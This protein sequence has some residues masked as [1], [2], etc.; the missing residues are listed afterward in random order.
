MEITDLRTFLEVASGKRITA[1]GRELNTVPSNVTTRIKKLEEEI[2]LPL[3]DRHSRGMILTE[4]GQRLLPYAENLVSLLRE[5][6]EA[7]QDDGV[8]R[9]ALRIG[10]METTAAVRL[11]PLLARFHRDCPQVKFTLVTGPTA[12]LIDEV[13]A[14]RLDGAFVAGPI[15]HPDLDVVPAFSEEL[16]LVTAPAIDT[17]EALRHSASG[18]LTALMFRLGCSYRQRLE[19]VLSG[20]GLPAFGR[21]ELG[22]LDGLLGCIAAGI[23][24]TLLPRAVVAGSNYADNLR[25]HALPAE[26]GRVATLLAVRRDKRVGAALRNFVGMLSPGHGAAAL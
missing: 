11:P 6:M 18:G 19:Q 9:G 24:V 3:F 8:V 5:A 10:S 20:M 7:A 23:G 15:E 14:R 25:M 12:H 22:T 2:G 4:A 1:A 26:V 13:V 16:V 21:I 17:L